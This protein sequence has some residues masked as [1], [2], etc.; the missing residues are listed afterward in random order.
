MPLALGLSTRKPRCVRWIILIAA[1]VLV[2]SLG[3]AVAAW[4][5]VLAE[6]TPS[7]VLVTA[8]SPGSVPT[9][10]ERSLVIPLEHAL[11]AVKHV[12]RVRSVA[13]EGFGSV[14]LEFDEG[15]DFV[16]LQA[17]NETLRRAQAT[18]PDG[19]TPSVERQ[20]SEREF[21]HH[22]YAV[23][24]DQH[25]LVQLTAW[26]DETFRLAVEVQRGVTR[27][28]ACGRR[29]PELHVTLDRA[30]LAAMAVSPD[31][32][33]S[34]MRELASTDPTASVEQLEAVPVG[35]AGARLKDVAVIEASSATPDCLAFDARAPVLLVDV[36]TRDAQVP[37]TLPPLPPGVRVRELPRE[38]ES[39]QF[40]TIAA[41]RALAELA[42][43]LSAAG[44][45][46]TRDGVIEVLHE[47]PIDPQLVPAGVALKTE[48]SGTVVRWR[49]ADLEQ[50]MRVAEAGRATLV[51]SR[52]A[53][54]GLVS[55]ST[56][57]PEHRVTIDRSRSPSP[58][59]VATLLKLISGGEE[60][61]VFG[62]RV[63]VLLPGRYEEALQ[64]TRLRDGR[65][66]ADVVTVEL[67]LSP[68]SILRVDAQRAVE[69][70]VG[71]DERAASE[72]LAADALP[73]G[74]T[75]TIERF[76]R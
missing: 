19:V 52:A 31:V 28:E 47:R 18:L 72:L 51:A 15:D 21:E 33:V 23:S 5:L 14:F 16:N 57:K 48:S 1:I 42:A 13:G 24:S 73:A 12:K 46:M 10:T 54:V 53:W 58:L 66:L 36:T 68:A 76:R 9:Q 38:L 63:R 4:R 29:A 71:L 65:S 45:T 6:K 7:P 74:V 61:R 25:T 37:P 62:N 32:V 67:T 11:V 2:L 59:E 69:L 49:G 3:V 8:V 41:E 44:P 39:T 17:V 70:P 26:F 55:P 20:P 56:T 50:L 27:V 75:L 35:S 30:R 40:A 60:L 64:L 22:R 34:S 43:T